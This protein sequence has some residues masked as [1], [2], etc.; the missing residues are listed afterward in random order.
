M[1]NKGTITVTRV[2]NQFTVSPK[3]SHWL[4]RHIEKNYVIYSFNSLVVISI[5]NSPFKQNQTIW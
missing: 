1:N 2:I 5:Q 4:I 3:H